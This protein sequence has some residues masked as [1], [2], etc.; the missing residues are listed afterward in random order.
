M[1]NLFTSAALLSAPYSRTAKALLVMSSVGML[2]ACGGGG[3]SS[4]SPDTTAP[5]ISSVADVSVSADQNSDAIDISVQD[6]RTAAATIA[7]TVTSSNTDLIAS[8]GLALSVNG[9]TRSLVVT[10][11]SDSVGNTMITVD[12][13]DAAGNT[14]TT[15]FM[16]TVDQR[17][18]SE[19]AI[20]DQITQLDEDAEP[21]FVNQLSISELV[22]SETGFDELVDN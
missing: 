11:T 6:D 9:G 18:L 21:L 20:L 7:V 19:S 10:P 12:A 3:Y 15:S 22:D 4:P 8:E 1:K 2:A 5:T 14:S 17:E 13:S 16:I